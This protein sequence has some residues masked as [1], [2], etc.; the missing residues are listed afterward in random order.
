METQLKDL[1][2]EWQCQ[3]ASRFFRIYLNP[4]AFEHIDRAEM[5]KCF[6][7]SPILRNIL[8]ACGGDID[9]A[10]EVWG[11][12]RDPERVI[13]DRLGI[14]VSRNVAGAI[15]YEACA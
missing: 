13:P 3:L 12:P 4:S 8:N 9:L 2:E 1:Y 7:Y 6:R 11:R 15:C 14:D 10:L 5:R